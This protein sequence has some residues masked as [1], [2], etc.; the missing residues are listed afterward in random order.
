MKLYRKAHFPVWRKR[1]QAV[2]APPEMV[3]PGKQAPASEAGAGSASHPRA[4]DV[5]PRKVEGG[6]LGLMPALPFPR[7]L[8]LRHLN[9]ATI[10]Y[11]FDV[12]MER[13]PAT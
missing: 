5:W 2:M 9:Q 12:M 8:P 4:E 6:R 11:A 13:H 10:Q 1:V 7:P 3:H